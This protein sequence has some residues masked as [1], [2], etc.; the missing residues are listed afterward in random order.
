MRIAH[1]SDV[2]CT[3]NPLS[4]KPHRVLG[5]RVMGSLN[6]FF[7]GRRAHFRNSNERLQELLADVDSQSPD[8]VICTGDL[9]Q[10]SFPEEFETAANLFG[11]RLDHP[12]RFTVIPGNHDRYTQ[13]TEQERHFEKWFGPLCEHGNFP[14]M[15]SLSESVTLIGLDPCRA[16]SMADSSGKIGEA[17]LA[18]LHELLQQL[19]RAEQF[20]ILALHYA[21]FRRNGEP[22]RPNHGLRDLDALMEI[23]ESQDSVVRMV[24]HGH[25]HGSYQLERNGRTYFCSGSATD[26]Y[27]ACGYNVYDIDSTQRL[28]QVTRRVW[29]REEHKYVPEKSSAP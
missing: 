15:K 5:K 22:D 7:G 20:V 12:S 27:G 8:H 2:H 1:F 16:T 25:I 17:Q 18:K 23:V 3:I 26:L 6:Y 10:M 29:S 19:K 14:F 13:K 4:R 21:P 11:H 28:V 24:I 9:T